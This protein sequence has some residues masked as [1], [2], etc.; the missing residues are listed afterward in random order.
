MV[1]LQIDAELASCGI[2]HAQTLGHDFLAN[3]ISWN[4]CNAVLGHVKNF[5]IQK[6]MKILAQSG[7]ISRCAAKTPQTLTIVKAAPPN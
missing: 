3:P 6:T 5:L 4:H 2:H 7:Q 1:K